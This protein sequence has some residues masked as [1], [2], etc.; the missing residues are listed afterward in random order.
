MHLGYKATQIPERY[1]FFMLG[2][3]FLLS[4]EGR[5]EAF[6]GVCVGGGGGSTQM[7][8]R[9]GLLVIIGFFLVEKKG[10]GFIWFGGVFGKGL[11]FSSNKWGFS[12]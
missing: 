9:W 4:N 8:G 6:L 5:R 3:L 1:F 10:E 2:G 12:W 7:G 11:G